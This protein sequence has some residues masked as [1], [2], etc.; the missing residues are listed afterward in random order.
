MTDSILEDLF[1]SCALTAYM[2][3][4]QRTR[5]FPPDSELTRRLAY[6]FYEHTLAEKHGRPRRPESMAG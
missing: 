2:E 5:Q 4:W 6:Q 3:V 1:H